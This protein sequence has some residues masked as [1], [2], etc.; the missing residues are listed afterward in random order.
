MAH[1]QDPGVSSGSFFVI[2]RMKKFKSTLHFHVQG[3]LRHR[4]QSAASPEGGR[5]EGKQ[6]GRQGEGGKGQGG[7]RPGELCE[8]GER[9]YISCVQIMLSRSLQSLS[10]YIRPLMWV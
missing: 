3:A 8:R 1:H 10:D 6:G 7:E 2:I 9:K 4:E 5:G